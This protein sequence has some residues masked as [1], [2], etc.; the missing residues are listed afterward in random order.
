MAAEGI[1][2]AGETAVMDGDTLLTAGIQLTGQQ[3]AF[4]FLDDGRENSF[5]LVDS[6]LLPFTNQ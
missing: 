6:H 4:Q 2:F 1:G 5:K 3:F